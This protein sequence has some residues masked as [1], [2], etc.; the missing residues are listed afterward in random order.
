MILVGAAFLLFAALVE[1]TTL[2]VTMAAVFTGVIAIVLG[3][4]LG[5]RLPVRN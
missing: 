1:L 3:L 4:V 2:T 5:E